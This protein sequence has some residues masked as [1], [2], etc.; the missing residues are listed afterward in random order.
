MTQRPKQPPVKHAE[1]MRRTSIEQK[2][3]QAA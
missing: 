3:L 2:H 1:K